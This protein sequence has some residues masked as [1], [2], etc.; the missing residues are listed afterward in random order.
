M[1]CSEGCRILVFAENFPSVKTGF[2]QTNVIGVLQQAAERAEHI[3]RNQ[4]E[5]IGARSHFV[6]Q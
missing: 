6:L 1:V 2:D 5:A 4:T 3:R